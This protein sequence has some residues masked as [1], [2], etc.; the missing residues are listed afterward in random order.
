MTWEVETQRSE[1]GEK[2]VIHA[3]GMDYDLD[4]STAMDLIHRM[5]VAVSQA[6]HGAGRCGT[7]GGTTV[8][9]RRY[10]R[11]ELYRIQCAGCGNRS[12]YMTVKQLKAIGCMPVGMKP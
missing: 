1:F 7:C 4:P 11:E 9:V 3:P 5:I 8:L 2:I 6:Q 12:E 10:G